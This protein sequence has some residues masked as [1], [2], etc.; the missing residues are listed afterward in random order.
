MDITIAEMLDFQRR[1]YEKYRGKWSPRTPDQGKVLL[2]WG[3]GE[4]GEVYDVIKKRGSDAILNNL[5]IR[6]H[7]IEEICDV[8]MYLCDVM[9]CFSIESP[10][11]SG[12][13]IQK[14]IHNMSRTFDYGSS[15]KGG[16]IQQRKQE[17]DDAASVGLIEDF[18]DLAISQMLKLQQQL[19]ERHKDVWRERIPQNYG[20]QLLGAIS[21]IGEVIDVIKKRGED[22]IM[23]R[24]EI[25]HHF[26]E[27]MGDVC[28]YLMNVLL[29]YRI[30]AAEFAEV[31]TAK[32]DYNLKRDYK[33]G[34]NKILEQAKEGMGH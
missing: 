2:L 11:F 7:F 27:E 9:L 34:A 30:A 24:T 13:Y 8:F 23:N 19:Y 20:P 16:R 12:V 1:L 5:E 6:R 14:C 3:V 21:E 4:L 17:E 10:E 26:I 18:S 31:Y 33:K 28:M 22:E 15:S 29:C 25:R 32:A